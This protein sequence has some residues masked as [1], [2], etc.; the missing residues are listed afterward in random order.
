MSTLRDSAPREFQPAF[1]PIRVLGRIV[2]AFHV[3]TP[4]EQVS[5]PAPSLVAKRN[6]PLIRNLARVNNFFRLSRWC[7]GRSDR[8]IDTAIATRRRILAG[9]VRD[10][11]TAGHA[12]TVSALVDRRN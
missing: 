10:R 4:S 9:T 12:L 1:F 3:V 11:P 2:D 7:K 8:R 6:A 5:E